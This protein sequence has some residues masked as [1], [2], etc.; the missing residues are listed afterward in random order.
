M[1]RRTILYAAGYLGLASALAWR[2]GALT[3]GQLDA[4]ALSPGAADVFTTNA[5]LLAPLFNAT[6]LLYALCGAAALFAA[7]KL[8][9]GIGRGLRAFSRLGRWQLGESGQAMTETAVSFPVLLITT[10]IMMQMALMYQAKNVVT[11][12]AFAAARAAVAYIGAENDEEPANTINMDG[13]DKLDKIN[14][15]AAM[16]CV[17]ISPKASTVLSGLPFVGDIVADAF[18]AFSGVMGSLPAGVEIDNALQRFAYSTFATQVT[19]YQATSAG[20]DEATGNVDWPYPGPDVGVVVNHRYYLPIPLVN[21]FIGEPWSL[22]SL[23]PLFSLD[24][25]GQYTFIRAVAVLPSEGVIK[26][27]TDGGT[28]DGY[29]D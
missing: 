18:S 24:L 29:W 10:L 7:G 11:Y 15:A 17:P 19:V 20:M 27:K 13:G 14:Q 8:A 25:P 4:A 2:A 23:P 28:L 22:I 16:A 9:L 5:P 3:W 12:A 21:R 6:I 26:A 1:T